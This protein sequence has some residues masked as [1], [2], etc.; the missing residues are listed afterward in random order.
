[1]SSEVREGTAAVFLKTMSQD[2]SQDLS[3][4]QDLVQHQDLVPM[5]AM[6]T[7]ELCH[8]FQRVPCETEK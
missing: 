7:V 2:L 5:K 8:L 4:D 1:M 6:T 3:L